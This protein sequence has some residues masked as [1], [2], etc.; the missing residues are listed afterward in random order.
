MFN[1]VPAPDGSW[2]A[3]LLGE[4]ELV[5]GCSDQIELLKALAQCSGKTGEP[6]MLRIHDACGG[7]VEERV[8]V[9]EG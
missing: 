5:I 1:V 2:S 7:I 8:L 6:I 9:V 3:E 4:E